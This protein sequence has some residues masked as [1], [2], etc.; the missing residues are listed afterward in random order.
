[1]SD[2]RAIAL[3][4]AESTMSRQK[5]WHAFFG[6]FFGTTTYL[7][8][9]GACI[10]LAMHGFPKPGAMALGTPVLTV[11]KRIAGSRI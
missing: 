3:L 10:Y 2:S 9:L 11:I 6:L 5:A 8:S 7:A 1:M 4:N